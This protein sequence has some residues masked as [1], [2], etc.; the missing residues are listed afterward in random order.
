VQIR[1]CGL[2][3]PEREF[4]GIAGRKF[5][6]DFAWPAHRLAVEVQGGI[7]R[8][9]AGAHSS[10]AGITRDCEK[11]SLAASQRWYVMPVT[12]HQVRSGEAVG[13]LME[14]FGSANSTKGDVSDGKVRPQEGRPEGPAPEA[15]QEG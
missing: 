14:F 15:G 10:P 5:R 7:F 13:W 2:P 6:F 12:S 3:I 8:G 9:K 4:V 11:I 1:S